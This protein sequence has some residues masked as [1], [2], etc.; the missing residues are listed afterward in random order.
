[1]N[2]S[3][4]NVWIVDDE[5]AMCKGALRAVEDFSYSFEDLAES[6]TFRGAAME[7][8][9]AF[10]D[11]LEIED[12]P[13]LLLLDGKLPGADGI[14]VLKQLGTRKQP[15]VTLM[16]TAYATLENAVKATKLGAF[17]FL[18]KPFTPAE[19]RHTVS[20]AAREIL[21]VRRARQLEQERRR[22]RFEFISVLAH[23]LKSPLAALEGFVEMLRSGPSS[24]ALDRMEA[25]I[26]G[27]RKLI[28][29]LLDLTALESGHRERELNDENLRDIA[30][31]T[32]EAHLAMASGKKVSVAITGDNIC[33]LRC[34]RGE[35]EML[36]GN[37]LTNAIK[38]NVEG[39]SV[40]VNLASP[41]NSVE[42]AV[43]DTGIGIAEEN[44]G[45]LFGEFSR[46]KNSRTRSVEGSGLGLSIVK[47][48]ADMYGAK[49][50]VESSEGKGSTFRITFIQENTV[51][52]D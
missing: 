19:L 41:P 38:Y 20:R 14:E 40:S 15:I 22:V 29:D 46:I 9:E 10:L 25:R 45:K 32:V 12:A 7:S 36:M 27:M 11:R 42:I 18:A 48:I 17:D 33:R 34:D 23:E 13:D 16:I 43:S 21:L 1:M 6:V 24:H 50:E 4:L 3:I 37:L 8:G 39:G 51:R 35:M 52:Q 30:E 2:N 31:A 49:T 28:N 26:C 47:K 44:R 5:P